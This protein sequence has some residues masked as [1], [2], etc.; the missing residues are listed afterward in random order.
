[1]GLTIVS[2]DSTYQCSR[3]GN[4]LKVKKGQLLPPCPRCAGPMVRS[5]T[6]LPPTKSPGCD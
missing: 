3:C 6:P 2:Q 5:E 1:M 4:V